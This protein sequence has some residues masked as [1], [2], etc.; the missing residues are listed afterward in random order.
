MKRKLAWGAVSGWMVAALLLASCAPA[1]VEEGAVVEEAEVEQPQYG[2]ILTLVRDDD[3]HAGFTFSTD[4]VSA[5]SFGNFW[6]LRG[7]VLETMLA[8]DPAKGPRGSKLW[9]SQLRWDVNPLVHKGHLIESWE[10]DMENEAIKVT[11]RE[12]IKWQDGSDFTAD[13]I[14]YTFHLLYGGLHMPPGWQ[15]NRPYI[16]DYTKP[17]EHIYLDPDDPSGRTVVFESATGLVGNL[18]S[19]LFAAWGMIYPSSLGERDGF[20]GWEGV[21]GTGPYVVTDYVPASLLLLERGP[22]PYWQNDPFHPENRLPYVDGVRWLVIPDL[23]TEIAAMRTGKIDI[24]GIDPLIS[25][26]DAQSLWDTNP[27]LQFSVNAPWSGPSLA[28]RNDTKPFDDVRVRRA[29]MMAINHDEMVEDLYDGEAV[30]FYWPT[31]PGQSMGIYTPLDEMPEDVK[32]LYEYHP[33]KAKQLLAEAGYPNGFGVTVQVSARNSTGVNMAQ[34]LK[35]YFKKV[36]VN[37]ELDVKEAGAFSGISRGQTYEQG[38][39]MNVNGFHTYNWY[40]TKPKHVIGNN[41]IV[42]DPVA[43]KWMQVQSTNLVTNPEEWVRMWPQITAELQAKAFY[44]MTPLPNRYIFWQPWVKGYN[45][46]QVSDPGPSN[47]GGLPIAS[48]LWIDQELKQSMGR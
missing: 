9:G 35:A 8:Y 28:L 48:G 25:L 27:E 26:E 45:G 44:I 33:D 30:K 5:R 37:L 14:V 31:F 47:H 18:W 11:A 22:N 24:L 17:K 15:K 41:A 40:H 13:D 34:I 10:I 12:G 7:A 1:A 16:Q 36:D 6:H 46:E 3:N 38:V 19:L 4:L 39:V 2:G 20:G 21:F 32:E 29:L 43:N 23:S 42:D